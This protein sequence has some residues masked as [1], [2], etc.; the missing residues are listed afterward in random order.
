MRHARRMGSWIAVPV[1]VALGL[2]L[3]LGLD[4]AAEP[5]GAQGAGSG[6]T[7]SAER[8]GSTSASARRR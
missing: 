6:F 2:V 4:R 8:C 7:L 1:G 3:A 5:A